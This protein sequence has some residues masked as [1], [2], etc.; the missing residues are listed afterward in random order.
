[1]NISY[2]PTVFVGLGGTGVR[3]LR[4]I[5]WLS[6]F[7]GDNSLSGC[8]SSGRFQFIGVDASEDSNRPNESVDDLLPYGANT[9]GDHAFKTSR[10][11][12]RLERMIVVEHGAI[13]R[14]LHSLRSNAVQ[15]DNDEES[16]PPF[17][18]RAIRAWF[19]LEEEEGADVFNFDESRDGAG[20]WRP[21]G[22]VGFF[23]VANE[24]YGA[25][26]AAV[27]T[28]RDL[29]GRNSYPEVQIVCSLAGGSGAGMFWD[30]AFLVKKVDRWSRVTGSFLLPEAFEHMS[31]NDRIRPNAY[32]ALSELAL[33]KNWRHEGELHVEYPING[34]MKYRARAGD[35][36]AFEKVYLYGNYHPRE[37]AHASAE[38]RVNAAYFRMAENI[39]ARCNDAV[40]GTIQTSADNENNDSSSVDAERVGKYI[41]STSTSIGLTSIRDGEVALHFVR[42]VLERATAEFD[43]DNYLLANYTPTDKR[44]CASCMNSNGLSCGVPI[45]VVDM[46]ISEN[47]KIFVQRMMDSVREAKGKSI[48]EGWSESLKSLNRNVRWGSVSP[49][50]VFS[51]FD[52]FASALE[53]LRHRLIHA[54][55]DDSG[56]L[57]ISLSNGELLR[58]A[59][60]RQLH[61]EADGVNS[62]LACLKASQG[63]LSENT[64]N[65]IRGL[66]KCLNIENGAEESPFR[67]EI[68][69]MTSL[70]KFELFGHECVAS[71]EERVNYI[72]FGGSYKL[73]Q[74]YALWLEQI[75]EKISEAAIRWRA[76]F[77][78]PQGKGVDIDTVE[79]VARTALRSLSENG[80]A[81]AYVE[82]KRSIGELERVDSFNR[83]RIEKGRKIIL[84]IRGEEGAER[85]L[86]RERRLDW[87]LSEIFKDV[88]DQRVFSAEDGGNEVLRT[89][90]ELVVQTKQEAVVRVCARYGLG[91]TEFPRNST[92]P[93]GHRVLG[94]GGVLDGLSKIFDQMSVPLRPIDESAD[95]DDARRSSAVSAVADL[96][97]ARIDP[98]V[99]GETHYSESGEDGYASWVFDLVGVM[100]AVIGSWLSRDRGFE[101]RYGNKEDIDR[102]LKT[103]RSRVFTEG[104]V[105]RLVHKENLVIVQPVSDIIEEGGKKEERARQSQISR[106]FIAPAS[107]LL[108]VSSPSVSQVK[109]D[110]PI[111]Y[112]DQLYRHGREIA[113][114]EEY[115]DAFRHVEKKD[116]KRFFVFG[117]RFH[118]PELLQEI[119]QPRKAFCGNAGCTYNIAGLDGSQIVCPSCDKP[120][121]NR[122]GNRGCTEYS[123]AE[124]IGSRGEGVAVGTDGAPYNCPTCRRP[125]RTY[126]WECADHSEKKIPTDYHA[127]PLCWEEFQRG[128]RRF[129]EVSFAYEKKTFPCPGC[130]TLDPAEERVVAIPREFR[131]FFEN[132]INPRVQGGQFQQL[133]HKHSHVVGEKQC[134][135]GEKR[136]FLFPVCPTSS[137]HTHLF[138]NL[139][140]EWVC[141]DHPGEKFY[142]CHHCDYPIPAA[143]FTEGHGKVECPRCLRTVQTCHYCSSRDGSVFSPLPDD[144]CMV[145]RCPRCN[146]LMRPASDGN[147]Q[148]VSSGISEAGFCSNLFSCRAGGDAWHTATEYSIG[149]CSACGGEE[150][151]AILEY[152]LL[153]EYVKGC[154]ICLSL[155]GLV[156]EG[157]VVRYAP[158]DLLYHYHLHQFPD[159]SVDGDPCLVCGTSARG[160]LAWMAEDTN[161]LKGTLEQPCRTGVHDF[162]AG[163]GADDALASLREV[164]KGGA[165]A[166]QLRPDMAMR[167]LQ[168]CRELEEPREIL[169]ELRKDDGFRSVYR[170][171]LAHQFQPM[172]RKRTSS[173]KALICVLEKIDEIY[174]EVVKREQR[175]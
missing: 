2:R 43:T 80:A 118:V 122:C 103:C 42:R 9:Q 36:S 6:K 94:K 55:S 86:A 173:A 126:W 67:I 174:A 128:S 52:D 37:S 69:A 73:D 162:L 18:H 110:F 138:R 152:S 30:A 121:R 129:S 170:G 63:V 53:G 124:K 44:M 22:R 77:V 134:H 57:H 96:F 132:G 136:H 158:V 175:A 148:V 142:T 164:V 108:G 47:E 16:D 65:K 114:A 154:P 75:S 95:D 85:D 105:E 70:L 149:T 33:L 146:N 64:K 27:A 15:G 125:I 5:L 145:D 155:T 133:V 156:H 54:K 29:S 88:V 60:E 171:K 153:G 169:Q 92:T 49:K 1:M 20:Q 79:R 101:V 165:P 147:I 100:V 35:P 98:T 74:L 39:L 12:P 163:I 119:Q 7:G 19:P 66:K 3:V 28:V 81:P 111:I 159:L 99:I 17:E 112:Y 72:K 8:L 32:A 61:V 50:G 135:N 14:V 87:I 167:V 82:L 107:T 40:R 115:G 102:A 93:F 89:A 130:V 143:E 21:L 56:L 139:K 144:G 127:C 10:S 13:A 160:I 120:I 157:A 68:P 150:K 24:Y 78:D 48:L 58:D 117:S 41:F 131:P 38:N 59:V 91:T 113:R 116:Q 83:E 71:Q 90:A 106:L 23:H 45:G 46:S 31:S 97:V 34:G 109:S 104:G 161:F 172:F 4:H 141:Q 166:P 168:F 62:L 137:S 123:L 25:I 11:L 84:A 51:G 140:N 76:L 151:G 26:K